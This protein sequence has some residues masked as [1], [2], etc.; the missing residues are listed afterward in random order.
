MRRLK[1]KEKILLFIPAYNCSNQVC[2]V[3]EKIGQEAQYLVDAVIVVDNHSTD[4]TI[5]SAIHSGNNYIQHCHF[6]VIKNEH[7]Y[8]LGGSHKTAFRYAVENNF[9]YLI[10]LH[11]D[12]Q[13]DINDIVPLLK[14]GEY[15][16]Y[17][18]ML[19]ARFMRESRLVGYS[20]FRTF[21]NK[22][23]NFLFSLATI[24]RIYDLGSGLNMYKLSAF[25]DYYYYAF[26]DDLTFNYVMLLG[27]YQRKQIINYFP[28]S[29]REEDQVSNV[30]LVSQAIT[31][32]KL[33]ISYSIKHEGMLTTDFRKVKHTCYHGSVIQ[34]DDLE[35][36]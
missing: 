32:L 25:K 2:R 23:Y 15:Q 29:W 18:C 27:S 4:G 8:G 7:N 11:G 21:G 1:L 35:T 26:P 28:I 14:S 6:S 31:V 19:G 24:K 36:E 12:D 13:A 9:D 10:V 33:I 30:K 20:K 16:K 3:I 5:K 17:D 22:V 34:S